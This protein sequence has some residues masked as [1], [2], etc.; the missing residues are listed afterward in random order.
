M[1]KSMVVCNKCGTIFD[2]HSEGYYN[3]KTQQYICPSCENKLIHS[4]SK[5]S[6]ISMTADMLFKLYFGIALL[7]SGFIDQILTNAVVGLGLIAWAI[8]AFVKARKSKKVAPSIPEMLFKIIIGTIIFSIIF[9]AESL[10]DALIFTALGGAIVAWGLLPYIMAKK[11]E[12]Q[13]RSLIPAA[14]VAEANTEKTCPYCGATSKG[15]RCE[16]CGSPL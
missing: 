7:G 6:R 9:E 15:D 5:G 2:A 1:A 14:A 11:K 10:G 8:A 4:S 3:R 13:I 16:Y 12:R